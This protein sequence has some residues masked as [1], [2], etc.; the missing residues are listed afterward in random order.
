MG[1]SLSL[2]LVL[3]RACASFTVQ[4]VRKGVAS[5]LLPWD[6]RSATAEPHLEVMRRRLRGAKPLPLEDINDGLASVKLVERECSFAPFQW[7]L[8]QTFKAVLEHTN[9][10]Y[11]CISTLSIHN[12]HTLE[13]LRLTKFASVLPPGSNLEHLY[14]YAPRRLRDIHECD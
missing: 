3:V 10:P 5:P 6:S 12:S 8:L 14:I 11:D 13:D 4:I 9:E 7:D 1:D 2:F